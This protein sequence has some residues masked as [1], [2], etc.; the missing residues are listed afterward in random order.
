V[1]A[2]AEA[3]A[4]GKVREAFWPTCVEHVPDGGVATRHAHAAHV[5]VA[6]PGHRRH[7][8][9]IALGEGD[10]QDRASTRARPRFKGPGDPAE[11][12]PAQGAVA[13]RP[14]DQEVDRVAGLRGQSRCRVA[15]EERAVGWSTAGSSETARS[16]RSWACSS[17][18]RRIW[19]FDGQ[20]EWA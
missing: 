8:D 11:E 15:V 13:A 16:S 12:D 5:D 1:L 20:S 6:L 7:N 19:A 2:E 3:D 10:E 17:S 4:T 14:R 9:L 18:S